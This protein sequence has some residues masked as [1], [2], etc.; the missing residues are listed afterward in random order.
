MFYKKIHCNRL[1]EYVLQEN[2][3]TFLIFL[4]Q[5]S[6]KVKLNVLNAVSL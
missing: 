4:L 3:Y 2:I 6:F 5:N 1:F